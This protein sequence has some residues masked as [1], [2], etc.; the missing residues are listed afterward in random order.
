MMI[1]K[2][3]TGTVSTLLKDNEMMERI[4]LSKGDAIAMD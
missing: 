4:G 2:I 1:A 3:S